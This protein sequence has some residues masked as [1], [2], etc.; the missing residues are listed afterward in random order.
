M[1]MDRTAIARVLDQIA[2]HLDLKRENPFR[3]RAFRNAARAV[4]TLPSDPAAML[5]DGSLADGKGLGAG[6]LAIVRELVETGR[7]GMLDELREEVPAGLVEMLSISGLGVARV[8]QIRDGLGIDTIPELE[9]AARDG[10]L[11]ALQGFG[12][13]TAEGVLKGIARLRQASVYLLAHHAAEEAELLRAALARVPGVAGA[14]VAGDVRRRCEIVGEIVVILIAEIPA[15]DVFRALLDVPGIEEFGEQDERRATLELAGGKRARVVVT[16]ARNLG[17]VLVQATGHRSHL[18][19]LAA[20]ARSRG[21]TFEGAALWHGSEF[22]ATPDEAAVYQALGLPLIPPE[23]REGRDE[24]ALAEA[25]LPRLVDRADLQGFLHC[26]TL[27]SDGTLSVIDLATAVRD[28]GYRYIGITDHS[29]EAAYAGG[30]TVADLARQWVEVDAANAELRGIRVLKGIE[31]DILADGRLDYDDEVLANFDFVI[32]SIHSRYQMGREDM[33][34]RVLR[35]LGNRRVTIF[36]HPTGRL[37][38]S[39]DPYPLDLERIF[40]FAAEQGVA[41]EI[42]AD[43]NRLDLDWRMLG[44]ARAAGVMI[45]IGADAHN[46]AGI[47]NVDLGIGVARKGGLTAAN[48]LNTRSVEDFLGFAKR[49]AG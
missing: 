30:L 1:T 6:T 21:Y 43:P 38:L 5:A 49:R 14:I 31:A 29:H 35:A 26:H 36:G 47:A 19:A 37:L 3:V 39:R 2:A 4:A 41:I 11:A 23:L 9:L 45:S 17:A 33:T 24:I 18:E 34:A 15:A 12:P 25:G 28:A 40:A 8:R 46:A 20:R 22:V 10:R 16:P 7:A 42:N 48:V 44:A 27:Y 32:A 13:R